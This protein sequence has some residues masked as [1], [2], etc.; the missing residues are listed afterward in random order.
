MAMQSNCGE[1]G[2][3]TRQLQSYMTGA[4]GEIQPKQHAGGRAAQHRQNRIQWQSSMTVAKHH[5]GGRATQMTAAD[6]ST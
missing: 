5:E 3:A 6:N 1:A 4:R 2:K